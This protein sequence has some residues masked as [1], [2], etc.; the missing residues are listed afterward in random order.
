MRGPTDLLM[1]LGRLV[2]VSNG[3]EVWQGTA[4][5]SAMVHYV[6]AWSVNQ[7]KSG[8]RLQRQTMIEK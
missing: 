1:R 6:C 2:Q 4:V 7:F 5:S 3:D 8:R